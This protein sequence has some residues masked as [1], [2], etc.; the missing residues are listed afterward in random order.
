M[1]NS[2]EQKII[3]SSSLLLSI[4]ERKTFEA[5][6]R[7]AGISG[8]SLARYLEK[9][10][11]TAKDLVQLAKNLFRKKRVCLIIDD[12]IIL[13]EYS[14]NI[15]GACDNYSSSDRKTYRS[16]CSVVAVLTDGEI[17]IPVDQKI[18]ASPE[19]DA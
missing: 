1:M 3:Y 18:W 15:P 19:F 8:D 5:L 2:T 7:S 10:P 16:L 4:G 12:T 17:T 11:A 6:A 9:S 14:K 13:K